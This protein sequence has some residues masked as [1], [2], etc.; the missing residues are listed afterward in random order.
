[1]NFFE[2]VE[3]RQAIVGVIGLG[4]VGLPLAVAFAEAGLRVVGIDTD[5]ARVANVQ[6]GQ[7]YVPD[8]PSAR[9]ASLVGGDGRPQAGAS[10]GHPDR[11]AH[12]RRKRRVRTAHSTGESPCPAWTVTRP[13]RAQNRWGW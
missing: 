1:M 3:S 2:K 12:R 13:R 5:E 4:Y 10:P 7:S 9:L 8:V 6:G 11:D